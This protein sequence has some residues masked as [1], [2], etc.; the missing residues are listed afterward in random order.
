VS[1]AAALWCAVVE[2]GDASRKTSDEM[3]A[4]ERMGFLEVGFYRVQPLGIPSGFSR[5][6]A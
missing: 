4:A 1:K 6:A 3:T 2:G 5:Q